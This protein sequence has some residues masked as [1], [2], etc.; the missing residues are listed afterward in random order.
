MKQ[1]SLACQD[2]LDN[3]VLL[4]GLAREDY[5]VLLVQLVYRDLLVALDGLEHLEAQVKWALL[6][7][8][9]LPGRSGHQECKVSLVQLEIQDSL[10]RRDLLV[11]LGL[12]VVKVQPVK[13]GV[14]EQLELPGHQDQLELLVMLVHLGQLEPLV[15]LEH[16][17]SL[18]VVV[19]L[20]HVDVRVLLVSLALVDLLAVS[21]QPDLLAL[22]VS[23]ASLD[24]QEQWDQLE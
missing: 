13:Q 4:V 6:D 2:H 19:I 18:V 20:G 9:E 15:L 23:L 12:Q 17:V 8:E 5:P 16:L 10:D 24:L 21:D 7:K 11:L 14:L 22:Q 3:L 1:V